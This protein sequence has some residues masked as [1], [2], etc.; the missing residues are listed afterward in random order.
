M[1]L[2]KC[3][4]CQG[5][6]STTAKTCPHCGAKKRYYKRR[7][8]SG[9]RIL[10]FIGGFFVL[11]IVLTA[12]GVIG[13]DAENRKQNGNA[14]TGDNV[15]QSDKPVTR[16]EYRGDQSIPVSLACRASVANGLNSP[17]EAVKVINSGD[18]AVV[19]IDLGERGLHRK[20]CKLEG[21]KVLWKSPDAE[22]TSWTSAS[23]SVSFTYYRNEVELL[24]RAYLPETGT[25]KITIYTISSLQRPAIIANDDQLSDTK[26]Q[27]TTTVE[28]GKISDG[29]ICKAAVATMFFQSPSII[30]VDKASEPFELSYVRSVDNSTWRYRCKVD[31]NEIIWAG[32]VDGKWGRWRNGQY[33]AEI[34]YTKNGTKIQIS[35]QYPGSEAS[36]KSYDAS[37]L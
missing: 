36:L 24:S 13:P 25:E 22:T 34:T 37:S 23:E 32:W 2:I 9:L 27:A 18:P 20:S 12:L 11:L 15:E 3:G 33:D 5:S 16:F 30:S 31:G 10:K 19:E 35:E 28:A 26:V 1:A 8:G 14:A 7:P 6:V 21:N 29:Q 17:L 4:E